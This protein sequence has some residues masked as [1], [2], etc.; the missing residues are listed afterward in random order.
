MSNYLRFLFNKTGLVLTILVVLILSLWTLG[1]SPTQTVET[2]KGL[3]PS[4]LTTAPPKKHWPGWGG[5]K[6][7]IVFGDSYTTTGF[8]PDRAPPSELNPLGN[9]DYPGD[10]SANGPNWVDFLTTTYNRT[11]LKTVNFAYGGATVDG[12][13][14][15]QFVPSVRS[16]KTQVYEDY[17]PNYVPPPSTFDWDPGN[18][19]FASFFGI[20][21]VNNAWQAG[22]HSWALEQD[23]AEYADLLDVVY[24]SGA[25]NFLF[26]QV[27]PFDRSPLVVGHGEKAVTEEGALIR[28]F[29]A[30]IT[31]MAANL[32]STYR[33]VSAFVF[34]THR[35]YSQV[36]D[37][38]CSHP[39][40][41][42][43]KNTTEYCE[44]YI[45]G[46]AEWTSFNRQC[47]IP[48]DQ[49]FWLNP[50]HPTFRIQNVTAKVVA[51]QLS[52][53]AIDSV[54]SVS[55]ML[56]VPSIAPYKRL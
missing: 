55:S 9:P 39:E 27:P 21:D 53:D 1:P 16:L 49:Y 6:H 14:I 24:Q 8:K 48:V 2:I 30:N 15:R 23:I 52:D 22:K 54:G 50:L 3:A 44:Q 34:D 51:K 20:N 18:T 32:S 5:I 28:E 29:N 40:S 38:P 17:L 36:L 7:M 12:D 4:S 42:A 46:T 45:K 10:T 41:C 11:F 25:R 35:V 31:R 47:S 26:M 33:D 13:L 37:N 56:P 43:I 19:L